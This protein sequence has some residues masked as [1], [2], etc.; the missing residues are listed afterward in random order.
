MMVLNMLLNIH[1]FFLQTCLKC[2]KVK[3]VHFISKLRAPGKVDVAI[4]LV[5][6]IDFKIIQNTAK[7]QAQ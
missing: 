4:K 6:I 3:L 5:E 2:E 7:T 1:D